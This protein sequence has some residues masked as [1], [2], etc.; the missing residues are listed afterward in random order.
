MNAIANSDRVPS[1]GRCG[2]DLKPLVCS[3][4]PEDG[5][6]RRKL[7][8]KLGEIPASS[9]L[10][11]SFKQSDIKRKTGIR[12]VRP[13][14]QGVERAAHCQKSCLRILNGNAPLGASARD[15]SNEFHRDEEIVA[16]TRNK[17]W[18]EGLSEA[19]RGVE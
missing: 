7:R 14:F 2:D 10:E 11:F 13:A 1:G 9:R 3:V 6:L 17:K 15:G 19:G 18:W 5:W 12:L 4:V 16:K 8:A